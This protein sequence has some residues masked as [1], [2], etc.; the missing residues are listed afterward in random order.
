[1]AKAWFMEGGGR[2]EAVRLV[3]RMYVEEKRKTEGCNREYEV[4]GLK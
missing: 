2:T 3:N 4:G 1:M